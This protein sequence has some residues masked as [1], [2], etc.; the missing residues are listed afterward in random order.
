MTS[1]QTR[2]LDQLFHAL[3]DNSR[4]GMIDRLSEGPASVSELAQPL[5]MA[6]PSVTKHLN[7]LEAGG[8]VVS[9]KTGR[10]RT[11]RIA[12]DA[13][14]DIEAWVAERKAKWN[15]RFDRL[16]HYLAEQAGKPKKRR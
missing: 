15:R 4:R 13:F 10:V 9:E 12:P 11:Y 7:V 14:G 2:Q 16:E 8:L 6:L 1:R 3:A 5:K